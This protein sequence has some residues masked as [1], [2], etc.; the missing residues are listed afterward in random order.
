MN[1]TSTS[2]A[3]IA[4]NFQKLERLVLCRSGTI[5]DAEI[6]CIAAKCAALKKLC[7]E[8]CPISDVGIEALGFGCPNLVEVK[9]KKCKG[10]GTEV[11]D[12][13]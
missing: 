13:L 12:Q 10:V 6:A 9:V 2:L 1:P 7:I 4:S 11:A 5:G 8:C 3:P